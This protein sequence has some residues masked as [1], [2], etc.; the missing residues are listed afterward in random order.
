MEFSEKK[1]SFIPDN[2]C[3]EDSPPKKSQIPIGKFTSVDKILKDAGQCS[4]PISMDCELTRVQG[5]SK[6]EIK[7]ICNVVQGVACMSKKPSQGQTKCLCEVK[8]RVLCCQCGKFSCFV[9][10]IIIND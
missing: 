4:S 7:V 2:K 8:V 10:L 1:K 3:A 5:M 6:S 9:F